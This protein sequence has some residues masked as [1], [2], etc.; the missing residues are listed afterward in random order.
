[1]FCSFGELP[2][3]LRLYGQGEALEPNNPEFDKLNERFALALGVRSIIRVRRTRI[4]DSCGYGV[5]LY[6]F[7]TP[8]DTL[9]K[10]AERKGE[11]N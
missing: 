9:L 10:W 8:R 2:F 7:V 1:M 11:C 6:D 3:I 5:P 4:Q